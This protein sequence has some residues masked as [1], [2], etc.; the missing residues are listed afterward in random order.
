M[1]NSKSLNDRNALLVKYRDDN[2]DERHV[3]LVKWGKYNTVVHFDYDDYRIY[4][5]NENM[6]MNLLGLKDFYDK[7]KNGISQNDLNDSLV[8]A[9]KVLNS[10]VHDTIDAVTI[11]SGKISADPSILNE[12]IK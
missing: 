3:A 2:G 1:F 12:F 8:M 11:K 5:G 4:R 6:L 9:H 7:N 10:I